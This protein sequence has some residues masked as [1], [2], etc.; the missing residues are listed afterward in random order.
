MRSY[1]YRL[2]QA[3]KQPA[4]VHRQPSARPSVQMRPLVVMGRQMH[5]DYIGFRLQ[6]SAEPSACAAPGGK[7]FQTFH[8]YT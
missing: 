6:V 2:G 1:S 7:Y 8:L 3:P 5:C 4:N